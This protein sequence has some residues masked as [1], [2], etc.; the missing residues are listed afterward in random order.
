MLSVYPLLALLL[1]FGSPTF[2]QVFTSVLPWIDGDT[3]IV[4]Q[5]TDAL[6]RTIAIQTVSTLAA[7]GARV[8]T[9]A[10]IPGVA[11]AT[12]TGT[13]ST[14]STTSRR[15]TTTQPAVV[16][17]TPAANTETSTSWYWYTSNGVEF[18]TYF[19]PTFTTISSA[20]PAPSGTIQDYS[21]YMSMVNAGAS[22]A[23]AKL[24]SGATARGDSLA[25]S[26]VAWGLSFAAVGLG[27]LAFL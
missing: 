23:Y 12:P 15:P 17:Y 27:A 24:A 2:A 21:E 18:S 7:T 1:A 25:T 16:Q 19:E 5:S 10:V 6:G 26:I 9:P 8:T 4:S 3:V 22:S 13:R 20:T 14:T 11:T